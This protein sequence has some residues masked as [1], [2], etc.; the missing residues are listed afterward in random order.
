MEWVRLPTGWIREGGLK[1][2]SWSNQGSGGIAALQLLIAIAH[3]TVHKNTGS[4][5]FDYA[6]ASVQMS[7]DTL[8]TRAYISRALISKG[9]QLLREKNIISVAGVKPE[10][11]SLA[12]LEH[13]AK[14]GKLPVKHLVD[15]QLNI[16]P[17]KY[18]THRKKVELNALKV[19]LLIVAFR[20]NKVNYAVMSYLAIE[21]LSGVDRNDIR[22]AIS[23]LC[24]VSMIY[25]RC[26]VSEVLESNNT[27]NMYYL[28]GISKRQ[29][30]GTSSR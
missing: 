25:I 23:W 7:Y 8:S 18:F 10:K 5:T 24:S 1:S 12:V 29:H 17:F 26:E 13:D 3:E 28:Q 15:K 14:W 11:Y 9:K 22:A 30:A 19:F 2:I 6:P 4:S 27:I 21:K 16:S 20:D